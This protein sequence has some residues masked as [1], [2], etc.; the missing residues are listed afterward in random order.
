MAASLASTNLY[1]VILLKGV[2]LKD[3][4]FAGQL[5]QPLL[6]CSGCIPY[7][8][9]PVGNPDLTVKLVTSDQGLSICC[10]VAA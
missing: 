6:G 1:F 5:L 2:Q 7:D 9:E 8:V 3:T 10:P 4:D